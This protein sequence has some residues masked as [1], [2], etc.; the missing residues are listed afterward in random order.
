M[1]L[2]WFGRHYGENSFFFKA[3][4]DDF[5]DIFKIIRFIK[6]YKYTWS[7]SDFIFGKINRK[8]E[9]FRPVDGDEDDY[10]SYVASENYWGLTY[11]VYPNDTFP[12]YPAGKEGEGV[13]LIK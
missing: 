4:T 5:V 13:Y 8:G 10:W 6:N 1:G 11:E 3:D 7:E 2:E 9:V 12:P